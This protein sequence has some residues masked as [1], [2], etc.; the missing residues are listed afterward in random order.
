MLPSSCA[1]GAA[2][3]ASRG[4]TVASPCVMTQS[5]EQPAQRVAERRDLGREIFHNIDHMLER[6]SARA[7]SW[8][9]R[10]ED[11]TK[12]GGT[13]VW[14]ALGERPS[15]GVAL[16]GGAA[17]AAADAVGVGELAMGIMIGYAAWQVLRKGKPV[18]EALAEA[19]RV[20]K[21]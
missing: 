18:G 20:E 7:G 13:R 17:I 15:I 21:P 3:H 16:L 19:Q 9:G 2:E 11:A 1:M 10:A 5:G 14:R 8:L 12:R 4:V 6:R